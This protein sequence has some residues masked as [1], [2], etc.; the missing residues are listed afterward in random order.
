MSIYFFVLMNQEYAIIELR[1]EIMFRKGNDKEL[2][3]KNVNET[4]LLSKKILHILYFLIIIAAI[5]GIIMLVKELKIYDFIL[6]VLAI[7]APLFVGIFIAWLF[8]PAVKWFQKRGIRRPL[9]SVIMYVLFL[10][11][12]LIIISAIVPLLSDQINDFAQTLP[13]VFDSMK[14]WIDDI[15]NKLS[16]IQGF[17]AE[18]F[19]AD[20]FKKIEEIGTNLASSL[21]TI[22]VS[23]IK[24][25]FGGLGVFLVGMIIGFY[26]LVGFD[27][28]NDTIITIFPKKMQSNAQALITTINTSLRK[29]V[30]GAL[31]DSTFVFVITSI[32]LWLVGLKAPLLFGLFCGL[33]N[34]IPYAGPYIGGAPAVIVG[35]SQSP[36]IG[37]LVL[38]VIVV[39]QF[40]EGNFI[41]PLIMSKTTKLHP[42]TIML[43][44]LI[45]GHFWGIFG[46][47]ISTPIISVIKSIILF[48]DE[49]YDIL[50]FN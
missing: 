50:N 7:V 17:D 1:G 24:S 43:G 19:E 39:I 2:N 8:D 28:V 6:E 9:G 49:K 38:V 29:F 26:L 33:T 3:M 31:L 11:C 14:S 23:I 40:L 34:V 21:P 45:F 15:F 46:M 16:A 10:G 44:L 32:G 48:F 41:Q 25:I 37:I 42:V 35:F 4:I 27:N 12:L 20:L 13:S 36:T 22:T 30:E 47:L 5:Y 18:A